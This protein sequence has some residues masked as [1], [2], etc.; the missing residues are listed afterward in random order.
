MRYLLQ[1]RQMA[2]NESLKYVLGLVCDKW[3]NTYSGWP[4]IL[5]IHKKLF[6]LP[7]LLI[8]VV[9]V[10]IIY[11]NLY[12]TEIF[13]SVLDIVWFGKENN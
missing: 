2:E 9:K 7:Y 6:F 3:L 13:L 10:Q 5:Q 12:H 8:Q 1:R 4:N 11:N